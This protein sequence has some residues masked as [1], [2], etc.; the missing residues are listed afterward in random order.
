MK[1]NEY[2]EIEN[3]RADEQ[4]STVSSHNKPLR[5]PGQLKIVDGI[6]IIAG[7]IIGS[8]IF[9]SPGLALSRCGGSPGE[10]LI[11]WSLSGFLVILTAHCYI[12]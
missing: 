5:R 7:I 4:S 2:A 3:S 9:S 12:E 10:V 6:A 1:V 8:G 11:A